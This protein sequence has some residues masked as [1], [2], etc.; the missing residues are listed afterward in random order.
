MHR[1]LN[2]SRSHGNKLD[3]GDGARASVRQKAAIHW[4][5]LTKS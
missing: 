2:V 5:K 1:L 4:S 3:L